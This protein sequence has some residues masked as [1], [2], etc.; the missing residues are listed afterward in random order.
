MRV[1]E[2]LIGPIGVDIACKDDGVGDGGVVEVAEDATT[3]ELIAGPLIHAEGFF[4]S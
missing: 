3:F 2:E 1:P 4:G